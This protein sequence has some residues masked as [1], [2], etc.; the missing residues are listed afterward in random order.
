MY[1]NEKEVGAALKAAGVPREKLFIC[2]KYDPKH[3]KPVEESF[4]TSLSDMGLDYV[5]LYLLHEPFSA[6]GSEEMLQ[7]QWAQM[8]AI[9]ASGRA[10]SIGVSNYIQHQ[11]ESILK[12]AKV[13][14]CINQIEFHPYLQHGDL[15]DFHREKQIA[16]A[17]YGPLTAIIRAAPG[18]VDAKYAELAK[19]YGVAEG[20]VALRWCIDQGVVTVTTSSSELRLQ[21]Y[22]SNIPNFKLTPKEVKDIQEL[23]RQKHYRAFWEKHFEADDRR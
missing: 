5:D 20:D 2:T 19:K 16:T 6:K 23:G 22:M 11:L 4:S 18:P 9:H 8:E 3:G 1:G 21:T 7:D 13:I 17:A 12:T 10:K 15:L 14:P